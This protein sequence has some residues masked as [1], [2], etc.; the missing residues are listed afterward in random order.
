MDT[1]ECMKKPDYIWEFPKTKCECYMPGM[2][3]VEYYADFYIGE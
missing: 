2:P 1:Y 3:M